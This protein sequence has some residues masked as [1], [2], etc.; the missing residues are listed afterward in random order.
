ML[1]ARLERAEG[2]RR[3]EADDVVDDVGDESEQKAALA[4]VEQDGV[5]E[6]VPHEKSELRRDGDSTHTAQKHRRRRQRS[7]ARAPGVAA[8]ACPAA[9]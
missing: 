3:R 1:S 6:L 4:V 5:R 8:W 9:R 7:F 2:A